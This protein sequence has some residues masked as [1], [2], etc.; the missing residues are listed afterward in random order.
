LRPEHVRDVR[1]LCVWKVLLGRI[2]NQR[3]TTH[4]DRHLCGLK[5]KSNARLERIKSCLV[6]QIISIQQ[7]I[8][9]ILEPVISLIAILPRQ[10]IGQFRNY[11][12]FSL[13]LPSWEEPR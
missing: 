13:H 12:V 4:Q 6:Q 10:S 5:G 3:L 7:E 8:G 2:I 9:L 11:S 1:E